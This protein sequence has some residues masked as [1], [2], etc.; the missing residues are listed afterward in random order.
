MA[1]HRTAGEW[2]ALLSDPDSSV[3]QRFTQIYG[4]GFEGLSDS[5]TWY[6][7]VVRRSAERY[8]PEQEVFIV[9]APGR[10]NLVGM[11][12][13]HRG[14]WINTIASRD[15]VWVAQGR[16]DDLVVL[17]NID[18]RFPACSFHI[19]DEVP[20]QPI[21]DWERWTRERAAERFQAGTSGHWSNYVKAPLVYLQDRRRD[22]RLRGMNAVVHGTIP[23][24]A[25]LSSSSAV[26]VGALETCLFING[27]TMAPYELAEFCG[28]AEWYVGTRGGSGDHASIKTSRRGHLS[29]I[30]FFPLRVELLPF[31]AEYRVVICNT[32]I[33]AHKAAG[34][35]DIFNQRVAAYQL[36]LL[37]IRERFPQYA[38]KLQHFRDLT[39][40]NLGVDE[41]TIYRLLLSLPPKATRSEL[42]AALP[43]Q[44]E[45]L[46]RLY[47]SHAE[48]ADGYLIRQVCLFGVAECLRSEEAVHRLRAGDVAGF[49]R[50]MTLSHEGDR[51]SRREHGRMMSLDYGLSDGELRRLIV[52]LQ[53]EDP[54]TVEAARLYR[55]PGGYRVSCPE[56]DEVVDI[57]LQVP[58]VVGA[59]LVGAGLGGCVAVLVHADHVGDLVSAEHAGY[60][61][62]RGLED[63]I[64]VCAPIEGAGLLDI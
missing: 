21:A 31:P 58:G 9:R 59:R 37:L 56:G 28:T 12:I 38:D 27:V 26:V 39:P 48:P 36:G 54:A 52:D 14:G 47:G 23:L 40:G 35:R 10:I 41:A 34:A 8:G 64:E 33:V 60:Y 32:G 49:G 15:V 19:G 2:L 55:Q 1:V 4:E 5:L 57:A 7:R 6:A 63:A 62:P 18:P 51:V 61:E 11:H 53:C 42:D 50:L 46:E 17:D 3:R 45:A 44:G 25:G 16:E 43:D 22:R 24:A 13:D 20:E 30:G 29:H